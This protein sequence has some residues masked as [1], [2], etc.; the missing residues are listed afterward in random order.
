E[1]TADMLD[2]AAQFFSASEAEALRALPPERQPERF[3]SIWTLKEAYV[4]ARGLGIA[5][6]PLQDFSFALA[7]DGCI[8]LSLA[9]SLGDEPAGWR[10][11]SVKVSADHLLAVAV[12]LPAAAR[13][14]LRV[15]V[16]APE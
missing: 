10:F 8:G 1:A 15:G 7:A 4:K 6:V 11:A 3:F 12:R 5:A 14:R 9:P 13:L 2:V 16:W